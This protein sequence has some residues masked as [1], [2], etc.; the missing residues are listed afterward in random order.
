MADIVLEGRKGDDEGCRSFESEAPAVE[1]QER[2]RR[3]YGSRQGRL[4]LE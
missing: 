4:W 2:I 3:P 1:F